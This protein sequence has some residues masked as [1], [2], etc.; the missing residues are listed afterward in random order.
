SYNVAGGALYGILTVGNGNLLGLRGEYLSQSKS[1]G[2]VLRYPTSG[3][4]PNLGSVTLSFEPASSVR[5]FP[6]LRTLVEYRYDFAGRGFFPGKD[7][8]EFKKNQ[9]T[10]TIAQIYNF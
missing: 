4:K 3:D 2:P 6:G 8:G 1:D 9:S 10:L 7:E 5:L